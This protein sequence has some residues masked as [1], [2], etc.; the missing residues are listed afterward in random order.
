MTL[1]LRCC[2]LLIVACCLAVKKALKDKKKDSK[3]DS[4]SDSPSSVNNPASPGIKSHKSRKDHSSHISTS[5][6]SSLASSTGP[7][8]SP[9]S[10]FK[11]GL[12]DALSKRASLGSSTLPLRSV[13]EEGSFSTVPSKRKNSHDEL[14]FTGSFPLQPSPPVPLRQQSTGRGLSDR[15]MCPLPP[16]PPPTDYND[17]SSSPPPLPPPR[18]FIVPHNDEPPPPPI[19]SAKNK[20]RLPDSFA[21]M[22]GPP[23]LPSFGSKPQMRHLSS[24]APLGEQE[25][26]SALPPVPT[27]SKPYTLVNG[28]GDWG[29]QK[30]HEPPP[31]PPD[32]IR[33]QLRSIVPDKPLPAR[34]SNAQPV[35]RDDD[36][37][38]PP[39]PTSSKPHLD[40]GQPASNHVQK[41]SYLESPPVPS[42]STK[43][44]LHGPP[45]KPLPPLPGSASTGASLSSKPFSRHHDA[46]QQHVAKPPVPPISAKPA[47]L[48]KPPLPSAKP[49]VLTKP[50]MKPPVQTKP[51]VQS[52]PSWL[53][54]EASSSN[55][56]S[57]LIP[58]KDKVTTMANKIMTRQ[59]QLAS[60][61]SENLQECFDAFSS[62]V[63]ALL[64][65]TDD[66]TDSHVVVLSKQIQSKLMEFRNL[67]RR[68]GG[69][70]SD[71]EMVDICSAIEAIMNLVNDLF[72]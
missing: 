49:A 12:D 58:M 1:S 45:I 47:F 34:P 14:K 68:T 27:S 38:P 28:P 53:R 4:R 36:G 21:R 51:T 60:R 62:S 31:L 5:A 72:R 11:S 30:G 67:T 55:L 16:S 46:S 7:P 24:Q 69:C 56:L 10:S 35:E 65:K 33:P 32:N 52:K 70:P 18:D 9:I 37:G 6:H 50:N 42:V 40:R 54:R 25:D 17:D 29:Q 48:P 8:A 61:K 41:H 15:P 20:P 63:S 43:P 44:S 39:L 71:G 2:I 26:Q 59:S 57:P 22:S 64:D 66:I 19:P 3:G 23:P 13:H